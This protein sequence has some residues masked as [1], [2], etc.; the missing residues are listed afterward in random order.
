MAAAMHAER[1]ARRGV[2]SSRSWRGST[3]PL[4]LHAGDACGQFEP[5]AAPVRPLTASLA[6]FAVQWCL[7]LAGPLPHGYKELE[8]FSGAHNAWEGSLESPALSLP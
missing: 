2:G 3:E 8:P 5:L 6:R 4:S 7:P 1:K